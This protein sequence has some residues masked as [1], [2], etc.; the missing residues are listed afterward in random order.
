MKRQEFIDQTLTNLLPKTIG[1]DS[2]GFDQMFIEAEVLANAREKKYGP[3]EDETKT[4]DPY[5]VD[6]NEAPEE[7]NYHAVDADGNGFWHEINPQ[8]LTSS[9][10]SGTHDWY[11]GDFPTE[12]WKQS[13]RKRP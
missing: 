9:W 3:F 1:D 10:K 5:A 6:W 8:L 12:N 13:L 11:C 7:A 4:V 2:F